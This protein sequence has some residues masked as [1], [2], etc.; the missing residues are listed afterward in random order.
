MWPARSESTGSFPLRPSG[1]VD[2]A[3]HTAENSRSQ[4]T[5]SKPP[6]HVF[7]NHESLERQDDDWYRAD[8]KRWFMTKL[9]I[10]FIIGGTIGAGVVVAIK[11]S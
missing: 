3:P 5:P 6:P 7:E 8:S 10:G 1:T 11:F 9:L 4:S 2:N